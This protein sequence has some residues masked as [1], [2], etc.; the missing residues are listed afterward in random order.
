MFTMLSMIFVVLKHKS[1]KAWSPPFHFLHSFQ[2]RLLMHIWIKRGKTYFPNFKRRTVL[3]ISWKVGLCSGSSLQQFTI[4]SFRT[5][6]F[7]SVSATTGRNAGG[8]RQMIFLIRSDEK[9]TKFVNFIYWFIFSIIDSY[10][11]FVKIFGGSTR[12]KG[13]FHSQ[14]KF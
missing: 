4:N 12:K 8:P 5:S 1:N 9:K 3:L 6:N 7:G 11:N 14:I 10:P 2:F 13:S